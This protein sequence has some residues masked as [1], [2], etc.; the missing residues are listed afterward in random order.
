MMSWPT[1][2][3]SNFCLNYTR[4]GHCNM[5]TSSNGNISRVTGHLCG[6]IPVTV[7]FPT[8]RQVTRSFN[9]FFDLRLNK[10]LSNQSWGWWFEIRLHPLR[11]QCNDITKW[12]V[13]NS[14]YRGVSDMTT[15]KN[16]Y[17]ANDNTVKPVYN[18]HPMGY[19]SA[20]WSSSRWPMAT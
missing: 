10:W 6:G 18:D 16:T 14:V 1:P 15:W 17:V 4:I 5:M 7:E 12:H 8:Q 2:K 3:S 11:R 9:V 13:G 20:F 19:F